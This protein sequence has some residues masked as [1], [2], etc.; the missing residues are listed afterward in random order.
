MQQLAA[1]FVQFVYF[2]LVQR[3]KGEHLLE[4]L[5]SLRRQARLRPEALAARQR[6]RLRSLLREA[7]A[8]PFWSERLAGLGDPPDLEAFSQVRPL[9]KDELRAHFHALTVPGARIVQEGTTSGSTGVAVRVRFSPEH[10]ASNFACQWF[11]RSWYGVQIGDPGVWLWGRPVASPVRRAVLSAKARL[12]NLLL[13]QIFDLSEETLAGWWR[14]IRAFRPVYFYGYASALDKLAEYIE[15]QG[16]APDFPVKLV[17][18]AAEV[19]YDFQRQRLQRVFGAP[20]ANEYGSTETGTIAFECPRGGWHLM[21]EHTYAEFLREDGQLAAPGELGEIAVTPLRNGSMPL[22]RYRLGDMGARA[23][24]PCPCGRP[25]PTMAMGVGKTV[26][27]VK[28]RAGRVLSGAIFHYI[29]RGL[30]EERIAGLS[31][32]RVVQRGLDD[33]LVEYVREPGEVAAAL[34]FFEGQM[35]R[36]IGGPLQ[37]EFREVPVLQPE[38]SGKL[39]YFRSLL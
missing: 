3:Y 4:E 2:P 33:F 28:T 29:N 24:A 8:L 7:R 16:P 32:F 14:Q 21:S 31:S 36:L 5:D 30:L 38:P 15:A 39:R 26:E 10:Q 34:R 27:V 22:L 23:T 9:S 18:S 6:E 12:N 19:L 11:G 17:S 37:I 13:L 1:R 25:W 35:R 20:V